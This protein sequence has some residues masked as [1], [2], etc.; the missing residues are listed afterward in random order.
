M[1]DPGASTTVVAVT[2]ED[3]WAL[4]TEVSAVMEAGGLHVSDVPVV[5]PNM[6]DMFFDFPGVSP[7]QLAAVL[8]A[9]GGSVVF[10]RQVVFDPLSLAQ[11]ILEDGDELPEDNPAFDEVMVSAMQRKGE[12]SSVVLTCPVQGLVW[13]WQA[14]AE[15]VD[16]F[17]RR[18]TETL[19]VAENEKITADQAASWAR[20]AELTGRIGT[21]MDNPE[22]RAASPLKRGVTARRLVPAPAFR[23]DLDAY[24]TAMNNLGSRDRKATDKRT[25]EIRK[26]LPELA[27]A[28]AETPEWVSARTAA[29]KKHVA[30]DFLATQFDEWAVH[31]QVADELRSHTTRLNHGSPDTLPFD[32]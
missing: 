22:Y 17:E 4:L 2:T 1:T 13:R 32:A 15:W 30:A 21:L 5:A 14:S 26:R 11:S 20:R 25:Q 29:A 24:T 28:L 7:A 31:V 23:G 12:L 6:P 10:V 9:G 27:A 3:L 18:F 16:D 8:T 19:L